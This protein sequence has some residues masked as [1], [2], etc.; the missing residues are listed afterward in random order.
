MNKE[1]LDLLEKINA[2]KD[3]VKSFANEGKLEEAKKAKDELK[4]LQD[5]FD[6]LKDLDDGATTLENKTPAGAP[7]DSTAEFAQAARNGFCVK[8]SMNEGTEADGG[9]TVPNDIQTRINKYKEAKFSLGQLVRKESVKTVKGSRTFKKRSQQTGFTKVG[10]GG[11]IGKKNTPQFERIDYEI[12]KYAGYFPVTNE[13][14]A[15]S[16]A[17]IA[18]TL[19]EWIGDEARVTENNLIMDAIKTKKEVKLS[20]LDDIKKV[21]NVTIGS[22]FKQS[23]KIITN[24]DGL[25]YLDTLKDTNGRY[26]LAPDPKDTMQMR[27]AVGGTYI[28]VEVIPNEDLSSTPTY[29]KTTDTDV[30][31]GKIYYKEAERVY[32]EVEEPKKAEIAGYFEISETKIPIIIGDLKEGIWYFDRAKTTIMTSNIASIGTLNAFEE[33]LTIYRA[34]ERED[35]KVRDEKAFVN[36][37]LLLK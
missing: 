12:S 14:L 21:L 29:A 23:S 36:G 17:N 32:T 13:L 7:T 25:Q 4:E 24:D 35:V 10:E 6:I 8:N 3:E 11:K 31:A 5:K 37:Y 9:Y 27:L 19:I 18:S 1:L 28:P 26:L 22:A 34:I 20:G 30:K 2:K 33:D 15:D 16:D